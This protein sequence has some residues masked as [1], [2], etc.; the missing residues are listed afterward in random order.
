MAIYCSNKNHGS[1]SN[2][3]LKLKTLVRS[4]GTNLQTTIRIINCL[5]INN[6]WRRFN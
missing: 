5:Q 2:V 6:G 1:E 4:V 3:K